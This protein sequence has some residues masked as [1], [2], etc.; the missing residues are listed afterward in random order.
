MDLTKEVREEKDITRTYLRDSEGWK[1]GWGVV[2][3]G[4]VPVETGLI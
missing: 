2:R 3:V 4:V 1:R